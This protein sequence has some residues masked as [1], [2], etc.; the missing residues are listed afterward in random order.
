MRAVVLL[1]EVGLAE[2]SPNNPLKVLHDLLE[3]NGERMPNVGVVGISNWALDAAKMNRAVHL[4]RPRM[5][6]EELKETI[7]QIG[8]SIKKQIPSKMIDVIARAYNQ[9][10]LDQPIMNF[11]GLRDL[12][13]LIKY[14]TLR[15]SNSLADEIMHGL[16][17]NFGGHQPSYELATSVFI[18]H[19][20]GNG[21][22]S[23]QRLQVP[24][25]KVIA[26]SLKDKHSRHLMLVSHSEV[27][28]VEL[29]QVLKSQNRSLEIMFGSRFPKDASEEFDNHSLSRVILCMEK[30]KVL[31]MKDFPSIYGSLYDM[32]N[33]NYMIM[34]ENEKSVK[35][36]CRIAYGP[37]SNPM[38]IVHENFK[39]VV[40]VDEKN[41]AKMESPFL[42]RFEK[43]FISMHDVVTKSQCDVADEVK[44]T[45]Q[46]LLP[47]GCKTDN[48]SRIVPHL[49]DDAVLSLVLRVSNEFE[50]NSNKELRNI[51]LRSLLCVAKP[52]AAICF[53]DSPLHDNNRELVKMLLDF[54]NSQPLHKGIHFYLEIQDQK[55]KQFDQTISNAFLHSASNGLY[56]VF[57]HSSIH[58]SLDL[59]I[60]ERSHTVVMADIESFADL[61]GAL[62]D[63]Y[64]TD[65]YENIF[66]HFD[67]ME[68]ICHL[69]ITKNAIETHIYKSKNSKRRNEKR[70]FLVQHLDRKHKS[71]ETNIHI[72]F[73][74]EWTYLYLDSL[75]KSKDTISDLCQM[76]LLNMLEND[77]FEL[78]AFIKRELPWAFTRIQYEPG[79]ER[80]LEQVRNYIRQ[81]SNDDVLEFLFNVVLQTIQSSE[82]SAK[83]I[84]N[85]A[86]SEYELCEASSFR[87]AIER[88]LKETVKFPLAK[89]IYRLDELGALGILC[90]QMEERQKV[91]YLLKV[92][93]D[94]NLFSLDKLDTPVGPGCYVLKDARER[95]LPVSDAV[96]EA[97]SKTI[98]SFD[99]HFETRENKDSVQKLA[100]LLRKTLAVYFDNAYHGIEQDY[101]VDFCDSCTQQHD[102][103]FTVNERQLVWLWIARYSEILK[104][105]FSRKCIE[106]RWN[107]IEHPRQYSSRD[108]HVACEVD[109]YVFIAFLHVHHNQ[110]KE[111]V[112]A[113]FKVISLLKGNMSIDIVDVLKSEEEE[114]TLTSST[115]AMGHIFKTVCK[116]LTSCESWLSDV[117]PTVW[118]KTCMSLFSIGNV[119][120]N[121]TENL[122]LQEFHIL[123]FCCDFV[124]L[125]L[126]PLK[127]PIT[128]LCQFGN[129]MDKLTYIR[130]FDAYKEFMD[131][132]E[133]NQQKVS[134]ETFN[135]VHTLYVYRCL[136][137]SSEAT[138][139]LEKYLSTI[140]TEELKPRFLK[141]VLYAGIAKKLDESESCG[142]LLQYFDLQNDDFL[143]FMNDI[144]DKLKYSL[145]VTC[146]LDIL[147]NEMREAMNC[148]EELFLEPFERAVKMAQSQNVTFLNLLSIAY[149]RVVVEWLVTDKIQ[150]EIQYGIKNIVQ[151]ILGLDT[152]AT[153]FWR[154]IRHHDVSTQEL[155]DILPEITNRL[156]VP[157]TGDENF[158][159]QNNSLALY[160]REGYKQDLGKW[161]GIINETVP[162]DSIERA[163]LELCGI[164][165]SR[166][167]LK[168]NTVDI[169]NEKAIAK[170][171][172]DECKVEGEEQKLFLKC[173]ACLDNFR[174]TILKG[175]N[176]SATT[177]LSA[178]LIELGGVVLFSKSFQSKTSLLYKLI[179]MPDILFRTFIPG[180]T[181]IP[182]EET[183][184]ISCI[185]DCRIA[186][187]KESDKCPECK[188]ELG[189]KHKEYSEHKGGLWHCTE[190]NG[191]K[192]T[193][194]DKSGGSKTGFASDSRA[195]EKLR[196]FAYKNGKLNSLSF[197]IVELLMYGC[198][199]IKDSL[200]TGI[201][202]FTDNPMIS[203]QTIAEKLAAHWDMLRRH[204]SLCDTDLHMCLQAFLLK[205]KD[206]LGKVEVFRDTDG[207]DTL[208]NW[209][210]QFSQQC[211]TFM[212]RRTHEV[213]NMTKDYNA[214]FLIDKTSCP[215][216][217]DEIVSANDKTYD[218]F[219]VVATPT[220]ENLLCQLELSE[221][222]YPFLHLVLR[223]EPVLHLASYLPNFLR[224]H[225]LTYKYN[226]YQMTRNE[227]KT[228]T[229]KELIQRLPEKDKMEKEFLSTQKHWNEIP[230]HLERLKDLGFDVP[231]FKFPALVEETKVEQCM[232][233]SQDSVLKSIIF[234]LARTQNEVID[235]FLKRDL[236]ESSL[237][238]DECGRSF[239]RRVPLYRLRSSEVF[240]FNMNKY[241][242]LSQA[243]PFTGQGSVIMY[244]FWKIESEVIVGL[245]E[246]K[247][248]IDLPQ[249]LY[250]IQ[251][252]DD[253]F[254]NSALL[255]GNIRSAIPQLPIKE[256]VAIEIRTLLSKNLNLSGDLFSAVGIL[257]S[258][259]CRSKEDHKTTIVEFLDKWKELHN[260]REYRGIS[261]LTDHPLTL[262]N[263]VPLY[264]TIES[265]LGDKVARGL[266]ESTPLDSKIIKKINSLIENDMC[267]KANLR[268]SICVFANRSLSVENPKPNMNSRLVDHL[269]NESYWTVEN[270]INIE[271][272]LKRI[273]KDI[274]LVHT[275]PLIELLQV[276]YVLI[277]HI[278]DL[279]FDFSNT[280][281]ITFK[282]VTRYYFQ[283]I[284][285][286]RYV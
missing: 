262:S 117:K 200:G 146:I 178:F 190:C 231:H 108:E 93:S 218:L 164:F 176:E 16:L 168:Q 204:L 54:Y 32:L 238:K 60:G 50:T 74:S 127:L 62:E 229:I 19:M 202:L 37:Y 128:T 61:N 170:R 236:S 240:R 221:K 118:H 119:I 55:R 109:I 248:Y 125:V 46:Q 194:L 121:N 116:Y 76:T 94:Q 67:A 268:D 89:L 281:I 285:F 25:L 222:Q 232:V 201:K 107:A 214:Y 49:S 135:Y 273:P 223:F 246:G 15:S 177:C 115:K 173:V 207:I 14:V 131:T 205:F 27:G 101:L 136:V 69:D 106:N 199:A 259:V 144:V 103:R 65:Q 149:L 192:I 265:V 79:C 17:R 252:K 10:V 40:V 197:R 130:T 78:K 250:E 105:K 169:E 112:D 181:N 58:S 210:L 147:E 155:Q 42:N 73:S 151:T 189:C 72:N 138:N 84:K 171:I 269:D 56:I 193:P 134:H 261:V 33:R 53:D 267:V 234:Y 23:G 260:L 100:A 85:I 188:R 152:V 24:V 157:K 156:D 97:V 179:T 270:P 266:T 225:S 140:E 209:E 139:I 172:I 38:C 275:K 166:I 271:E 286:S 29:K 162:V 235:E 187:R 237:L 245:L 185:C 4:S 18:K 257:L 44:H 284:F 124:A 191:F 233:T 143:T 263:I 215:N 91:D 242:S 92:L 2:I 228:L 175:T 208:Y 251:F 195:S 196:F 68:D 277:Y 30:G 256:T 258:V 7:S 3:P 82:T 198:L 227:R 5:T 158:A 230:S 21:Q 110:H 70:C 43:Q 264:L 20:K 22:Y 90:D 86:K 95:V 220:V 213:S 9:Y 75:S 26:E 183:Y 141:H 64:K 41:I 88:H 180:Q 35:Q 36:Y 129:K 133:K 13:A 45:L 163:S 224:W 276:M 111:L 11:H 203:S 153:Y 8:A 81:L 150:Q 99:G 186:L 12:Y 255:L 47:K 217:M 243:L 48:I 126:I 66:I 113:F 137:Y 77:K 122:D 249:S 148:E 165:Y 87:G 212:A 98:D 34:K 28:L 120:I 182:I 161:N 159:L 279:I 247:A 123:R 6:L 280:C 39:C 83:W 142:Q 160:C 244:D 278:H 206:Y 211:S 51:C 1:D 282:Q 63:F 59:R 174:G 52:E 274:R 104:D 102:K 226:R 219:R 132:L 154:M 239:V 31:I 283:S 114:P 216:A 184:C 145:D 96:T 80:S 254:S 253:L 167:Y 71:D 57:T 272:I 241:L